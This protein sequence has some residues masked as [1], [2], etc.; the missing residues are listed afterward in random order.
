MVHRVLLRPRRAQR[1]RALVHR[2]L[3]VRLR[4]RL[5]P[6]RHVRPGA[7]PRRAQAP[8][9]WGRRAEMVH[10]VLLRRCRARRGRALVH[11]VLV[12][13]FRARLWPVRHVR[14]GAGPGPAQAPRRWGR[15]AE[16]VHRVLL[17]RRRAEMVHRV[18]LR[19]CRAR[20][21]RALVHRVLAAR[22]RARLWPVRHVRCGAGSGPAQAPGRW[23]RR[24]EMVH[25]VLLRRRRAEMV[26]RV[27][28]RR[29]RARRGRAL[30]HEVLPA[31]R[32]GGRPVSGGVAGGAADGG[33]PSSGRRRGRRRPACGRRARPRGPQ[34]SPAARG[35]GRRWRRWWR[36]RRGGDMK[37]A[38]EQGQQRHR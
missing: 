20:R 13:R 36:R 24:A 31:G 38:P 23:G 10:R 11:M 1:G 21:G 7:G 3:A 8:G 22:F 5:W 6:V 37:R 4:A 14:C 27:L 12:V 18:L 35:R 9:R 25:R 16:M 34:R 32:R 15:R 30:L 17:R 33:E 19:R 28:A 29:R 26:H 2:V